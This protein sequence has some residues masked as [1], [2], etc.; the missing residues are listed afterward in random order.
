MTAAMW[1]GFNGDAPILEL[2]LASGA[3]INLRNEEGYT[4]L[5]FSIDELRFPAAYVLIRHPNVNVEVTHN[6]SSCCVNLC[7][8]FDVYD[9][10]VVFSVILRM[11]QLH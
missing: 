3:N 10:F 6:V 4:A 5:L 11:K 7:Y 1:A 2:L 8:L 9:T